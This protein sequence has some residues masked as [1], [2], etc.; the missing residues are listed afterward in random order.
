MTVRVPPNTMWIETFKAMGAR[1]ATV[2]WSEVYNALQQ[3]VVQ[4]AEAPL[5]SL[6]GSK[7]QETRKVISLTGHFTAFVMWPI[8]TDLLQQAAEG[9]A[10]GAA[11]G[12]RRG[13]RRDDPAHPREPGRVPRQVQGAPASPSSATSTSRLP[14][15]DRE[16]LQGVPEVDAG[17]ARDRAREPEVTAPARAPPGRSRSTTSRRRSPARRSWSSSSSPAGA[18]SRATSPSSR[19]PGPARWPRIAFAWLVFVGAAAGFKYGMHVAI[20][21]L[22]VALPAPLRRGAD[23]GRRRA[24]ARLPRDAARA[25]RRSSR[26]T[27]GTIRRRCCACRAASPTRR[28]WSAALCM[29]VRYAPR[30]VAPLARPAAR[31]GCRC[32]APAD[33]RALTAAR[34]RC[35]LTW[36][37]CPRC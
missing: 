3:H 27:P 21:M 23:G 35:G 24:R 12:G 25:R 37:T 30:R 2:Q 6:W 31:P 7:L 22:V 20:D 10:A 15:G 13:R 11:R 17:P 26:S 9:R 28:W 1:P 8:N 18:S 33:A 32:R 19:R 4:G 34:G 5:G 36:S 14:E 29:L 16:R